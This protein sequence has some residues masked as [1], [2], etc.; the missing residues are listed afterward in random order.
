MLLAGCAGQPQRDPK[1]AWLNDLPQSWQVKGKLRIKTVA[2]SLTAQFSWQQNREA[3]VFNISGPLGQG[4]LEISGDKNLVTLRGSDGRYLQSEN[5]AQ[6]LQKQVGL[7]LSLEQL[8]RCLWW[9]QKLD[10]QNQSLIMPWQVQASTY[11]TFAQRSIANRLSISGVE[12]EVSLIIKQRLL[13]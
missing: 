10:A 3:F 11:Q 5:L 9:Q 6:L 8:Q 7:A 12:A 4:A 1:Q 2:Q 13:Q